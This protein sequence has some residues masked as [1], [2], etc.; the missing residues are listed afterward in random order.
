MTDPTLE[1]WKT[2]VALSLR[3]HG[4]D[5]EPELQVRAA[6]TLARLAPMASSLAVA[7]TP[8]FDIHAVEQAHE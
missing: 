6:R 3:L 4:I 2:W 7:T 1:L 8:Q 5:A